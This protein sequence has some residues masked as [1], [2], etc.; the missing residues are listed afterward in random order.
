MKRRV[1]NETGKVVC[2][3]LEIGDDVIPSI[4]RLAVEQ[5][6]KGGTVEMIGA[7]GEV[8]LGF[9]DTAN[10]RYEQSHI[11]ENFELLSATGNIAWFGDEP[12][13]HLHVTLGRK[14]FSVI[15]GHLMD[16][17]F[18]SVLCEVFVRPFEER[19]ERVDDPSIGLKRL[20]I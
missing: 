3:R 8:R 7:L 9:W 12:F 19:L 1:L 4:K 10:R 6:I 14:D 2:A 16:G 15:G 5:G 11:V 20:D 18:V 13:V 17:S